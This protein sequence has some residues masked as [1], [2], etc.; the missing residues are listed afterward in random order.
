MG[1]ALSCAQPH[2][3]SLPKEMGEMRTA[4]SASEP[5]PLSAG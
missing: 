5:T 3:Y 4:Q 2:L 1:L